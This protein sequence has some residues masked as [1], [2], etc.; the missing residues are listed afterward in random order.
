MSSTQAGLP[1]RATQALAA[2]APRWSRSSGALLARGR[3][4]LPG[5][6]RPPVRAAAADAARVPAR[7]PRRAGALPARTR[8]EAAG[9][10][11]ARAAL[12][13]PGGL[14]RAAPRRVLRLVGP[15]ELRV[16]APAPRGDRPA[17]AGG[18]HITSADGRVVVEPDPRLDEWL[19]TTGT[20]LQVMPLV[21]NSDG[22]RLV[23]RRAR[24]DAGE[25]AGPCG[26]GRPAR[27]L[28]RRGAPSRRDARLR[29]GAGR[30]ARRTSPA[31]SPSW[32]RPSTATTRSCFVALPAADPA[33]DYKSI[34]RDADAVV[35][36]NY[37]QHWLTSPPGPDRGPG[38]VRPE[39]GVDDG[40]RPAREA[41]RGD[42][43]IRLRLDGAAPRRGHARRD[44]PRASRRRR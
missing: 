10:P 27:G 13:R 35:L 33:Y 23:H 20:D 40:A 2:D 4:R 25:P 16:P 7:P 21:N 32:P 6:R 3:A 9:P 43:G 30:D 22:T 37:D 15:R 5:Q 41:G 38:L 42:R 1:R 39:P 31:S 36:M 24:R 28:R 12:P 8:R 44:R 17:G 14:R 29:G 26:G 11:A 18:L 34:G 19:R